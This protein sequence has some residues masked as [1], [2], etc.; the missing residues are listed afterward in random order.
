MIKFKNLKKLFQSRKSKV[1][2]KNK[3]ESKTI[4][5]KVIIKKNQQ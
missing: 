5:K 1:L 3:R 2:N 4:S